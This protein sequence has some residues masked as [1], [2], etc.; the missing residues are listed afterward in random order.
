MSDIRQTKNTSVYPSE[1]TSVWRITF[2]PLVWAVHFA[3]SY[4]ATSVVCAKGDDVGSLRLG[5]GI[6]TAVALVAIIWL[7]WRAW[8][9]WDVVQDR[10]WENDTG[11]N[12]DRHQFLG[13]AAF[14]LSMISFIGVVYVSLPPLLIQTC[15]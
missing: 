4:G 14:L 13:H 9:H 3:I 10:D 15:Q 1:T 2:A 7:A 8:Q 11:T 12:E 6:A 5:L